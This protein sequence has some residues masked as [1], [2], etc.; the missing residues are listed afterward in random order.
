MDLQVWDK[1]WECG[2]FARK[3]TGIS[4]SLDNV[5]WK[6]INERKQ[7]F[8]EAKP[9]EWWLVFMTWDNYDKTY[10]HIAVVKSINQNWS[11]NII[12]SNLDWK[13]TVS[14]RTLTS[15]DK[16]FWYYN[17]TPLA[18]WENWVK[19]S[20]TDISNFN[21]PTFK[22]STLKTQEQK[23]KYNAYQDKIDS[24]YNNPNADFYDVIRLSDWSWR[25]SVSERDKVWK[26]AQVLWWLD[27]LT[28]LVNS[29]STWPIVWRLKE[30]NPYST[31]VAEFKAVIA[32]LVPSVARWIFNEV[33]VL[34]DNDVQNYL[35]TLPTLTKTQDQ[36]KLVV[37]A[38]LK[39]LRNWMKSQ[40]W[41][42]ARS[43]VNVSKF[44]W[45]IKKMDETINQLESSLKWNSNTI[46]GKVVDTNS[47]FDKYY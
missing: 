4:W 1:W 12:E 33:W 30:L 46:N 41:T 16:V 13:W 34:T 25:W 5:V 31:D 39:T 15:K 18:K 26:Y 19:L 21:N 36:N 47:I 23:D 24:V 20:Q 29:Q 6:T 27:T 10:W 37:W 7:S 28:W 40:L 45:S 42:M 17:D 2:T 3:Y 14:E 9:V 38:L 32:G 44:E 35:K 22:P 11:I 43:G 8:T